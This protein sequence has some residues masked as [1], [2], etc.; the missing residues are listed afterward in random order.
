MRDKNFGWTV[1]LQVK[2]VKQQF[3][4]YQVDVPYR[5]RLGGDSKVSGNLIG[6]ICAGYKIIFTI[7]NHKF[8]EVIKSLSQGRK[9]NEC[10]ER[11]YSNE[12]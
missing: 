2:A 4:I 6:V 1:E 11:I 8:I 12:T 10:K 5:E 9:K 7:L 3:K